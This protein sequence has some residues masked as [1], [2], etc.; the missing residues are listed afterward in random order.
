MQIMSILAVL[1][2]VFI[3]LLMQLTPISL[4]TIQNWQLK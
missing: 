2:H 4:E 1:L 3:C